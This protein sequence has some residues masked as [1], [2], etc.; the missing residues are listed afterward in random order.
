MNTPDFFDK[1]SPINM[2]DPL[3]QLLGAV[4]N[5]KVTYN[6]IDMVKLAGHS[7]PT[8]A[9]A[10]IMC[11]LGLKELF[12]DNIPIRGNIKIEMAG[13]LDEGVSG[14]IAQCL[15]LITG[16]ANEGGFKGLG[17]AYARNNR[18]FFGCDISGEVKLTRL[19]TDQSIT[20]SYDPSSIPFH[21][22]MRPLMQK[23]GQGTLT[24]EE[25]AF[26]ADEWQNRVKKILT[27]T[28]QWPQMVTIA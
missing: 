1:I 6:Y 24:A 21:P 16:A 22:Q 11:D 25:K 7:C 4:L 8:V 3:A 5:G 13:T 26:F 17:P 12:G 10:W 28:D 27:Q 14:V 15:S 23:A 2:L 9:G 18:L 19:D 20:L